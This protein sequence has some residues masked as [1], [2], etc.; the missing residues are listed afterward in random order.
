MTTDRIKKYIQE[1]NYQLTEEDIKMLFESP[2]VVTRENL[3]M[4]RMARIITNDNQNF[5]VMIKTI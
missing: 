5:T 4:G 3:L 2:Q 1:R